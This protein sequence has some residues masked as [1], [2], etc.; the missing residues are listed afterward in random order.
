MQLEQKEATKIKM[1]GLW[2]REAQASSRKSKRSEGMKLNLERL[3]LM[4]MEALLKPERAMLGSKPMGWRK[5]RKMMEMMNPRAR[6]KTM[7]RMSPNPILIL[8]KR[9][10]L[11]CRGHRQAERPGPEW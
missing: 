11:M 5:E 9:M 4:E 2:A 8:M 6:R 7:V 1:V 3:K 10:R